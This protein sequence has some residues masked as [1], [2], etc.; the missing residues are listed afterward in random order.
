MKNSIEKKNLMFLQTIQKKIDNTGGVQ[1]DQ[2][3][4]ENTRR[5]TGR[6]RI[7]IAINTELVQHQVHL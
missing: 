4:T 6:R 7:S 1:G 2:E 5:S 3:K